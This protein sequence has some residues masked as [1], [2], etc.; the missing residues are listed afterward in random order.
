MSTQCGCKEWFRF[1][2][3]FNCLVQR[4]G[5]AVHN[6]LAGFLSH[7]ND[8]IPNITR[9]RY[10]FVVNDA[11]KLKP[12]ERKDHSMAGRRVQR[13]TLRECGIVEGIFLFYP[14][15]LL[16]FLVSMYA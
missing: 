14:P 16:D 12:A 9:E 8:A 10:C 5:R 15:V 4:S 13:V 6:M 3:V 2:F 7:V 11:H 1:S